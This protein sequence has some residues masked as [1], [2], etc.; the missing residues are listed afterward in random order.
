MQPNRTPRPD[1]DTRS[2]PRRPAVA[3]GV[4]VGVAVALHLNYWLWDA[5]ALVLGLPVN[6]FYHVV[7]TLAL[8]GFMLAL[9][10]RHWPSFLD[11]EDGE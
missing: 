5:D 1:P 6:L 7:F 9:V 3:I 11:E 8:S 2:H 4:G 10:R